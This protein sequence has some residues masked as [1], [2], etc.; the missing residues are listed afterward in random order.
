MSSRLSQ[1]DI[2]ISYYYVIFFVQITS[3]YFCN[4]AITLLYVTSPYFSDFH[5]LPTPHIILLYVYHYI[6]VSSVYNIAA[7]VY[8]LL[9]RACESFK[10]S[11]FNS[12]VYILI[13]VII[14][15]PSTRSI[16]INI[17]TLPI[18]IAH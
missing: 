17:K 7:S 5:F 15:F 9:K 14:F 4:S 13:V 11:I 6:H 18:C 12:L 3:Q 8:C 10:T 1:F 16:N 2:S